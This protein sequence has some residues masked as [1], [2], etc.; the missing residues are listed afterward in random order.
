MAFIYGY[1]TLNSG[2]NGQFFGFDLSRSALCALNLRLTL[3]NKVWNNSV[4]EWPSVTLSMF[5]IVGKTDK[6]FDSFWNFPTKATNLNDTSNLIVDRNFEINQIWKK[7][8]KWES[9]FCSQ[10][11]MMTSNSPQ[12]TLALWIRPNY[13][14]NLERNQIITF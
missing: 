14:I 5:L 7:K 11:P 13:R 8:L 1:L 10:R 6:I 12:M 3:K 9:V 4:E 2:F